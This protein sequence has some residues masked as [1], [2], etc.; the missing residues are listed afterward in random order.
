MS[1]KQHFSAAVKDYRKGQ[2]KDALR[3]FGEVRTLNA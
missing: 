1:W 2:L 3:G